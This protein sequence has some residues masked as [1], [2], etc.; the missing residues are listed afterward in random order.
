MEIKTL[1]TTIRFWLFASQ[2]DNQRHLYGLKGMPFLFFS[3]FSAIQ[4][5][6]TLHQAAVR[7]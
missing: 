1:S 7:L 5:G 3:L 2:Q 6:V 4:L